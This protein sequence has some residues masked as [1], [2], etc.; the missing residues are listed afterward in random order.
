MIRMPLA[1]AVGA[2]PGRW[3]GTA[4]SGELAGVSTDTRTLQPGALYFAIRGLSHD[5]HRFIPNAWEA[6]ACA[7]VADEVGAEALGKNIAGPLIVVNDTVAALGQLARHYRRQLPATV[8]AVTGSNGKTTTKG[9]LA[10]VLSAHGKCH[11]AVR[12]FNNQ[13]GVPLTLLGAA[14]DDEFL[15]VEIGTNAPGEIAALAALTDPDA[16][17]LTSIG[18]A[19]LEGLGG[20]DGV[21]REKMALF[22]F[23]RAGG[24]AVIECAAARRV[25]T[26]PRL[27]ELSWTTFGHEA[28][29]DVCVHDIETDLRQTEA[30]LSGRWRLRLGF[31]G[32]HNATNAAGVFALCRRLGVAEDAI[33]AAL[34]TYH[35]P[36]LRMNVHAIDGI[37]VVEDCYNA[38]P[39]SMAAAIDL[40]SATGPGRRV[41]VVGEMAEL[42]DDAVDLHR[43][44][45][46][47]AARAGIEFIVSIGRLARRVSEAASAASAQV[48]TRHFADATA[49]AEGLRGCLHTGDTVLI[50][51]S[52]SA[53]LE[54]IMQAWRAQAADGVA[55]VGV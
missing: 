2:M 15:V 31:G 44:I 36:E 33:V 13:I 50:K 8:I 25:G 37:T 11:A 40:L 23:V 17:L 52:R 42:G 18:D 39:S 9:M 46:E 28:D 3:Q 16:G 53:R 41:L 14:E 5:G 45:G 10:H 27:R 47:Q 49:A 38:N 55:A 4:G 30:V 7:C 22:D 1:E 6:G 34:A 19:H 48:R 35:L 51:G 21:V 12:S 32:A 29:A 54:R 24:D 43:R 20:R 26:L